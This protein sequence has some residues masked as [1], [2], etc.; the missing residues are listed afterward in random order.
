MERKPSVAKLDET[1]KGVCAIL[2][3]PFTD[4]GALDRASMGTL[5][6]FYLGHGANAVTILGMMGEAPK[7]SAVENS[8]V[9]DDTMVAV[10][11][12]VPVVVGVSSPGVGITAALSEEAMTKGAA[13][14]MVAPIPG[15]K[16]DE[17]ILGYYGSV[18]A[19]I[20]ADT[21]V[22]V[23]DFPTT[24]TVHMS[25]GVLLRLVEDYPQI[26]MIKHEDYPGLNK[27]GRF[28][29]ESQGRRRVSI[30]VGN[31]GIHLPQELARGADGAMTGFAYPEMLVEVCSRFAAGDR[32]GAEDIF[33]CYLPL[34]R[35]EMQPGAGIALRKEVLR[36]RGAIRSNTVRLP[37]PK[38]TPGDAADLD[39]LIG[40]LEGRLKTLALAA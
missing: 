39:W 22:V 38:L 14:V 25:V 3:T 18:L 40:R 15:L 19:A 37:G 5:V 12:R 1:A 6:D 20:G 8:A 11:G 2:A 10:A 27:L 28:R 17:Q 16:T 36:R 35:H 24:T 32:Q 9:I 33:D 13:G 21:P 30:L 34:V 23:Q 26:V 7:L 29:K 31:G 4:D